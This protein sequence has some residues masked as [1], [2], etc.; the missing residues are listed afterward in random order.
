MRLSA[1]IAR[2]AGGGV[3]VQTVS[4]SILYACHGVVTLFPYSLIGNT[5]G[6]MP[7]MGAI[8]DAESLLGGL[9]IFA[10]PYLVAAG[11][12][13][14]LTRTAPVA[15]ALLALTGSVIAT[16]VV[17]VVLQTVTSNLAYAD[18]QVWLRFF[19]DEFSAVVL[20][21]LAVF[22]ATIGGF[23]FLRSSFSRSRRLMTAHR[24]R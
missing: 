15:D 21:Q 18:A 16:F 7:F 23:R 17:Q 2:G 3:F 1:T 12:A 6:T 24:G 4:L 11:V 13:T 19:A 9:L 22:L 10:V 20:P 8:S 5:F 14:L